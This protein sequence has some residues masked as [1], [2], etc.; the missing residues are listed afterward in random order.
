MT[1]SVDDRLSVTSRADEPNRGQRRGKARPVGEDNIVE[2]RGRYHLVNQLVI[3]SLSREANT[4]GTDVDWGVD[5]GCGDESR[6]GSHVS[7]I[8]GGT[9]ERLGRDGRDGS[10]TS[11]PHVTPSPKPGTA[12]Q[13]DTSTTVVVPVDE[14]QCLQDGFRD[15]ASRDTPKPAHGGG[16]ETSSVNA[17]EVIPSHV[18]AAI[19]LGIL[20]EETAAE[21]KSPVE[22]TGLR[23]TRATA[24]ASSSLSTVIVG[25]DHVC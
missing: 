21:R 12:S 14:R 10:K 18:P 8:H 4:N 3:A 20:S 22:G 2:R 6:G 15:K 19:R 9:P 17:R 11:N 7:Q 13:N 5:G 23:S 25:D 16:H 1:S 24:S